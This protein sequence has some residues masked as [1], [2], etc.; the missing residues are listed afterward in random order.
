MSAVDDPGREIRKGK[1]AEQQVTTKN[2]MAFTTEPQNA[3]DTI[4]GG[5]GTRHL[6][7]E[8]LPDVVYTSWQFIRD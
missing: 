4:E 2:V 7:C 1:E 5:Y 6:E 3:G 8:R